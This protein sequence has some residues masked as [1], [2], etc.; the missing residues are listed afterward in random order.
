MADTLL[1]E[2]RSALSLITPDMTRRKVRATLHAA[3]WEFHGGGSFASVWLSPDGTRVAKVTKPDGGQEVLI[4]VAMAHPDNP[5]LPTVYGFLPLDAGGFVVE[6]EFL[7]FDGDYEEL[8]QW[9]GWRPSSEEPEALREAWDAIEAERV[10][11]GDENYTYLDWDLHDENVM[12]RN[13]QSVFVDPLYEPRMHHK[14]RT[15]TGN[16]DEEPLDLA[17]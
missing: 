13:G 2:S 7:D 11:Y 9:D 10:R 16:L 12:F 14:A 8:G 4:R 15:G 6:M 17:A 1:L 5:Y 3:G